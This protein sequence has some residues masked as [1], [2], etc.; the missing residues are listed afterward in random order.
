[1]YKRDLTARIIGLTVFA[2]GIAIL[3][4][5]FLLAYKLFISPENG[6]VMNTPQADGSPVTVNLSRS[7]LFMVLQISALFIMVL[8]GSVIASRGVQMYFAGDRPPKVDE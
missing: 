3:V 1:M 5:S 6:L 8:A 4:F 7:A 2:L